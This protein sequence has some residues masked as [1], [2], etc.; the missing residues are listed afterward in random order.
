M[1]E[2]VCECVCVPALTQESVDFVERD[3][4]GG[5]AVI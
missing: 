1:C 4:H 3:W 2:C 5:K